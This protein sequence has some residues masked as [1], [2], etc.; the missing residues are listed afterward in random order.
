MP[1]R[2]TPRRPLRRLLLLLVGAALAGAVLA[3][4][5]MAAGRH[6]PAQSYVWGPTPTPI[7]GLP[8]HG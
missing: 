8:K 2:P 3:P 4:N 6:T 1:T 5:A 7:A